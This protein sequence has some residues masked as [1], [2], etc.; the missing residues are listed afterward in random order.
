MGKCIVDVAVILWFWKR[1]SA[2]AELMCTSCNGTV[3]NEA[4]QSCCQRM[5][6]IMLCWHVVQ[7]WQEGKY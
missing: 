5:C 1:V 2:G 3:V 6:F 7:K 4:A